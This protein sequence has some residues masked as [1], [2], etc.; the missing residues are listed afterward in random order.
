MADF[1]FSPIPRIPFR[2]ENE[3]G[4]LV[5]EYS[6]D[7]GSDSY[8]RAMIDKGRKVFDS[9]NGLVSGASSYDGL[10]DAL[11]DF[12]DYSFDSPGEYEFLYDAF[13][14]NVFALVELT[15]AVT[16]KG[17]AAIDAKMKQTAALYGE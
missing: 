12:L 11:K 7:A 1:V 9:A 3:K 13:N 4:E 16:K 2:I 15:R 5:K 8:F 17:Q 6:I 10:K 14:K